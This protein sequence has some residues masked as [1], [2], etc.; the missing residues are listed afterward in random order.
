LRYNIAGGLFFQ[1]FGFREGVFSQEL[2]DFESSISG[3]FDLIR[4]SPSGC[5]AQASGNGI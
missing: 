2:S 4:V 1:D 3:F 5:R